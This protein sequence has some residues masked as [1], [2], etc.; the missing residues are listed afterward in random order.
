LES[1]QCC[2]FSVVRAVILRPPPYHDASR[3]VAFLNGKAGATG[4]IT[5]S[6]LPDYE[7]WRRQLTSFNSIGILSGWTFNATG[8]DLPERLFGAR[9]SGSL[10]PL[11]GTPALLG[12][13]I[14]PSDDEPGGDEVLVLGYRVWQRLFAGDP[15]VIGKPLMLEG[16]PHYIIGVMPA[17]FRFP[18]DDTEVWAAIKDNMSGMPRNGRFMAAVGRLKQGVSIAAAQAE[19]DTLEAQLEAA[20]PDT[21][22][23]WRVRLGGIHDVA[24]GDAK[25]ALL[26]L[27][28]A[29]GFVLLIACAN[30]ANLLLARA[31]SRSRETAI[32]LALGAS[33]RRIVAQW[34]TEN[35]VL[36]L[37]GG[38]LGVAIAFAVARVIVTAGPPGVPRLDETDSRRCGPGFHVRN[39]AGR[40]RPARVA[41][42]VPRCQIVH[43]FVAQGGV[44]GYA[45]T[46]RNRAGATLI[47]CEVA[48]AMT[49]AVAG[50]LLL[51]SYARLAAVRPGFEPAQVL[52]LKV[53][54]TPPR[55]RTVAQSKQFI[56]SA[57]DRLNQISGVESAAA[58]SQVPISDPSSTQ[59]FD[60]EDKPT[61]P[62]DRPA[63]GYRAVSASYFK[64]MRI[65]IVRGRPLTDDDRVDTPL[66]VVVNERTAKRVW[67]NE[68]PIGKRIKWATGVPQFDS[69]WHTVVGVAADVK[70]NG[71]DKPEAAAIYAPYTQRVFPWLRWTGFVL[72][73][74][75]SPD[76]Y[77]RIVRQEL[78]NIDPMQPIYEVHSLDHVIAQ[79]VSTRRFTPD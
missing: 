23:G 36:S 2:I 13:T 67:P 21:N 19:V 39:L 1:G 25:P 59:L 28:A 6:S 71:L 33:R 49:L 31:T 10:F 79:S 44:G 43:Q 54:L 24:V 62:G 12:R 5:S 41:A 34:L 69:Q 66:V 70:S 48:L 3:V 76:G 55:Y 14:E 26:T 20:Y 47:V 22:R 74:Q 18:T 9:V 53:F 37:T 56:A 30:V 8:L 11:L 72:R 15:T 73:T 4:S 57:L 51:K 60:A 65:P 61:T 40:R 50:A 68:N 38:L 63:A 16:R 75:G 35:L 29:V 52:S 17:R 42:G 78:T 46:G 45:T 58:V 64:T 32:R 77:A 27:V 7:D